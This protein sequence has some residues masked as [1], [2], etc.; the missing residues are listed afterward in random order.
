MV[1]RGGGIFEPQSNIQWAGA[2]PAS[3]DPNIVQNFLFQEGDDDFHF[4]Y[5]LGIV[6]S[7]NVQLDLAGN[8]SDGSDEI[9]GSIV[10]R[11]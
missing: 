10:L 11:R 9:V 2:V 1:L 5:G 3:T 7:N 8:I 4:T 6:L